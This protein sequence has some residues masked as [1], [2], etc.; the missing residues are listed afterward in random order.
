MFTINTVQMRALK[1]TPTI[2]LHKTK[3]NTNANA[4]TGAN[5]HGHKSGLF[6][7]KLTLIKTI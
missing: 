4:N 6:T 2:T 3:T 5:G 7:L 1:L